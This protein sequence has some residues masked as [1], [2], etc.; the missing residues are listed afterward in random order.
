MQLSAPARAF[1]AFLRRRS[2]TGAAEEL[3][4]SQSAVSQHIADLEHD[5]GMKLVERRSRALTA[6]GEL[7]ASHVL[8]AEALLAQ[9]AHCV[10]ALREPGTGLL[11]ISAS[12]TPGTYLL[13]GVIAEFQIR[14]PGVR[15]EFGLDTAK[16]VV[17][18]IRSHAA[19]VGIVGAYGVAPEIEV[20]PLVKDEIVVVGARSLARKHLTRD[21]IE[22]LT[23]IS[24]EEGSGTSALGEK[25]VG[26]VGIIPRH[27]LALPSWEAV[28]LAVR[29]GYGI[30]AL[31][32]LA[33]TEELEARSLVELQILPAKAH[34]MI[35]IIRVRD[36]AFTPAAQH[37]LE[38]LRGRCAKSAPS[39][40]GP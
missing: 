18:K 13:P 14:H 32:R 17:D 33:V 8:R 26:E 4:I 23:W 37:F 3:H 38:L 31:S 30:A 6:A 12:G 5:I 20:E 16:N 35:S 22:G 39:R 7:L 36:A 9:G 1:A 40:L 10:R 27:R 11:S 34:R 24:R 21:Q 2:F 25:L 15:I 29:S 28:K 19:E